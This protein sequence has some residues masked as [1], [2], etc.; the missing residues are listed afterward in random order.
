MHTP[1]T[2]E[3]IGAG[4]RGRALAHALAVGQDRVLLSDHDFESAKTYV[5]K[6]QQAY[7]F[8]DI[9]AV[10]CSYEA[11]WEADL[12]FL[13]LPCTAL[14]E[15]A[16]KI[17]LVANQKVVVISNDPVQALQELLPNSKIV[18]A[19]ANVEEQAFYLAAEER[20]L[21]DCFITAEDKEAAT[22]VS[23]LVKSIGF[24]PVSSA[25]I[26]SHAGKAA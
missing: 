13:D 1:Q 26:V 20:K 18:Q 9:E 2:I 7:P 16:A 15:A 14:L 12:I 5:D 11:T 21:I 25:N 23:A 24:K 3:I 22:V 17:K 6:L 10:S 8:Y 19:F 4:S